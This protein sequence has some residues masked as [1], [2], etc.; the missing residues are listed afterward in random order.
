MVVDGGLWFLTRN[1]KEPAPFSDWLFHFEV[2]MS[3]SGLLSGPHNKQLSD[4]SKPG[5]GRFFDAPRLV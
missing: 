2:S 3:Q 4:P 5:R 1:F